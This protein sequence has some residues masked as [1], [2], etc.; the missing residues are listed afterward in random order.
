[1]GAPGEIRPVPHPQEAQ[2]RTTGT[3]RRLAAALTLSFLALAPVACGS[4]EDPPGV[5]SAGGG[6]GAPG[7]G[8]QD[9]ERSDGDGG[10]DFARCMREEGVDLADPAGDGSLSIDMG[11]DLSRIDDAIGACR[12]HMPN[13]GELAPP[14]AEDLAAMRAYAVCM[15]E[16]GVEMDDPDPTGLPDVPRGPKDRVDAAAAACDEHLAGIRDRVSSTDG[17]AA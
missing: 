16:Q 3:R 7:S 4:S 12:E 5:A 1:M 8:G 17:G 2:M 10:R 9:P 14:A 13:G 6:S 11:A 15:R